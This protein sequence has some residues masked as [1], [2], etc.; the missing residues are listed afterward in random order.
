M[1]RSGGYHY[2][3][4]ML[5]CGIEASLRPDIIDAPA[6]GSQS[7][8]PLTRIS[9]EPPALGADVAES[10]LRDAASADASRGSLRDAAPAQFTRRSFMKGAATVAAGAVLASVT[11]LSLS[12]CGKKEEPIEVEQADGLMVSAQDLLNFSDL[13]L[14]EPEVDE[15]GVEEELYHVDAV[16]R[17]PAGTMLWMAGSN[18]AVMTLLGDSASPLTQLALFNLA[19]GTHTIVLPKA[20]SS[21]EGFEIYEARGSSSVLAWV[22]CNYITSD[23]RLYAAP[24]LEGSTLGLPVLFDEGNKDFDPPWLCVDTDHVFWYLLPTEGGPYTYDDSLVKMRA[25]DANEATVIYS[26]PGHLITRP[27]R[28]DHLITITPR[29]QTNGV[30][31]ILTAYDP[32]ENK[33]VDQ[34]MMPRSVR[35]LNANYLNGRFAFSIEASYSSESAIAQM[36]TYYDLGDGRWFRL[37]K[38]PACTPVMSKNRLLVK[39]GRGIACIDLE[40]GNYYNIPTMSR[41]L[42]Y[43]EFLAS[44]G[45][46]ERVVSYCTVTSETDSSQRT[47]I[48]RVFTLLK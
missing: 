16:Y 42:D 5:R 19:T 15:E 27:E 11:G 1:A 6:A 45:V 46:T 20:V 44:T 40:A 21:A 18:T 31:Y 26:S 24:I 12:A 38:T 29:A 43:G 34:V 7:R 23:W 48:I 35:V 22:E 36:G 3:E 30:Y 17:Y 39:S 9:V 25:M 28:S 14:L 41:S 4:E 2:T 47:T 32:Y 33:V 10:S 37:P 13:E 8:G